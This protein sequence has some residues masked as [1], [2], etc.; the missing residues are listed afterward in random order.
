MAPYYHQIEAIIRE[1]IANGEWRP[2]DRVPSEE[3]LRAMFGVSRTT[4]RQA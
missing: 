4:V 2:G 3:E 1:K